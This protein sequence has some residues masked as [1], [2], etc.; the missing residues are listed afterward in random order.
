MVPMYQIELPS[1]PSENVEMVK[2]A[3]SHSNPE[4]ASW[5]WCR[6]SSGTRSIPRTSTPYESSLRTTFHTDHT[7]SSRNKSATADAVHNNMARD[8][9][10][11]ARASEQERSIQ[12]PLRRVR[13]P[14]PRLTPKSVLLTLAKDTTRA[15]DSIIGKHDMRVPD[16]SVRT[17]LLVKL[18]NRGG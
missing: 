16:G 13:Q 18:L 11:G 9:V 10:G 6:S 2:L 3:E 12:A 14:T 4:S 17:L 8:D 15:V 7:T 5:V 1:V